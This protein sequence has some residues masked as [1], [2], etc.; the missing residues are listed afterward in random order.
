MK[1]LFILILFI[2]FIGIS[3][4][5][6]YA[7]DI[8]PITYSKCLQC[9]HNGGI[10]PFSLETY[11][12]MVA[13]TGMIQL[14]TANG[15][16]PPWP[17]D[18]TFRHYS[19][20]NVLTADEINLIA[21]WIANGTPEGNPSLLP[22]M[23]T[24][25]A[26]GALGAP[27]LELQIPTYSSTASASADDYVCFS[28]PTGL[29][30]NRRIRAVEVVPGTPEIVHHVLVSID[31]F[32]VSSVTITPDCMGPQGDMI[33]AYAPGSTPLVYPND[34][35]NKF[36]TELKANGSITLAMHYPEGSFGQL[37]ST[38][39]RIYFYPPATPIRDIETDFLI[40]NWNFSLPPNQITTVTDTYG[41]T[42]QDYSIMSVFPHMH[43]LGKDLE[44]LAVTQTNDTI[45]LMRINDW[46]F[47]W[48]GFYF[49]QNFVKIPAGSMIYAKGHF[50]N[51]VS[52]SNPNPVTVTAGLDTEDEMFLVIFQFLPYQPGDE[53]IKIEN[54]NITS[55]NNI[56]LG[57]NVLDEVNLYPNPT[58]G[59]VTVDLNNIEN[60]TISVYGLL[61]QKVFSSGTIQT[62]TYK[63][64]LPISKGVY[65][66]EVNANGKGRQFR[67]TKN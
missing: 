39:I 8:A 63:L 14:V 61:G 38:K 5:P 23:P 16:M 58:T 40:E 36:G 11:A 66:V 62:S 45:N 24:F 48:Q 67:V 57:N 18:T 43:L 27:D 20:E 32:P 56:V 46:D 44:C 60:A 12:S 65:I 55:V 42:T 19:Y 51:T 31:L 1:H 37:D 35:N 34:A 59:N 17:P 41:P 52:A 64:D 10:A 2:P 21:T 9:H 7:E 15:S 26:N 30:Q 3:Q 6:N 25:N 29:T 47:E 49:F 13:N 50:D 54:T 28:I 33:Y 53:N 4:N 22:P